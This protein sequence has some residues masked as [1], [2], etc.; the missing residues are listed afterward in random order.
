[1]KK[2]ILAIIG[3]TAISFSLT[4]EST[5]T[6]DKDEFVPQW[7]KKVVWYQIFPE[8]FRNGD[9]GN[10]PTIKDIEGA[11]PHDV[12]S[13]WQIHP[14]ASDWYELQAYEK[15]NGKNIWFNLQRRRYG[16]D[17]QGI[18][19]KLDYIQDLGITAIYLNPI[20]EAPS[21]H[22]YDGATF[23]H[24]DPNFGPD[25][26][27]DK[28]LIKKEIPDDPSSWIWT[29]ADKLFLKLVKQIHQRKM[30]IIIDGVFNHMGL[31]SWAFKDVVKNQQNSKYK[32]WFTIKS[33]D[34]LKTGKKFD[35]EGWFGVRELPELREDENGIVDAPKKY[36]FDITKR[37]MDPNNNGNPEDGIDGWRLDVAFCVK[38][39]FWK[40]WRRHVKSINPEAYL[41]AEV[42]DSIPVIKPYLDGNE[43]DA[44]MNYDF[45]FA[46]ADYFVSDK[47]RI[48]TIKFDKILKELREAFPGGVEYVQQNL[49]DSHDT[50]R[51]LSHIV[52]RDIGS[53]RDWAKYYG[54]SKGDNPKYDTRKPTEDEI[55]IA[56]LMIIFQMTYVGA[57]M[58]YYGDEIGMWGAND[59]DC[60]KPMVWAD[61]KYENEIY[62]P[63]QTKK[64]KSDKVEPN[65]D[66]LVHY[67]NLIRIRNENPAL[68]LGNF[69]TVL[70]DNKK[71]LYAFS[72]NYKDEKIIVV[73]NNNNKTQ[74]AKIKI[75]ANTK[76]I[77]LL[78]V[79]AEY[80]GNKSKQNIGIPAKWGVILKR[81]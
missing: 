4:E 68:Q 74:Y 40:D 26:N 15:Q 78:N 41:T 63:D 22:K 80:R 36:I 45:A 25:P 47:T 24:V 76:W 51:L 53:F 7:A 31:N 77:D 29:S 3:F 79:N 21:L 8:R 81:N 64:N 32:D 59:P 67:K 5:M 34:D 50:N 18:I 16:G 37:W 38:H 42:I 66:L 60:R 20:F 6:K 58:V 46:C 71:E 49:F 11:Y 19:D 69:S 27:G 52:N 56:K 65:N 48:K 75:P 44:V 70:V 72:R 10:D 61:L 54:I 14:W 1:M 28:E 2:I 35:Y 17:L 13:P 9:A 39:P 12:T 55:R 43:F 23:H 73:I 62:S 57:P 33:W 30:Y